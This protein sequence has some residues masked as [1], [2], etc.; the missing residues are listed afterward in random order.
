MFYI[1]HA[2]YKP[3]TA[4]ANRAFSYYRGLSE[5]GIKAHVIY[6]MPDTKRSKVT[7][8]FPGITFEY[9]WDRHYIDNPLLRYLSYVTYLVSFIKRLNKGDVVYIY[10]KSDI[11]RLSV[12]RKGIKVFYEITEH[13]EVYPPYGRASEKKLNDYI[14]HCKKLDGL[15]VISKGLKEYFISKGVDEAKI[16][17]A[18]MMVDD[19]RFKNIKKNDSTEQ[20]ITFC[21]SIKNSINGVDELIKAFALV[22][23]KYPMAK[24][25][26]LGRKDEYPQDYATDV[27][28]VEDLGLSE[29]VVF[30]GAIPY[31]EAP[32]WLVNSTILVLDRPD[33]LQAK[34]GFPTKLG[35]YLLSGN[36]VVVTSVGDIPYYLKDKVNA[37]L[38][39]PNL[40]EAFAEKLLW[41]LDNPEEAIVVGERGKRLALKEFNYKDVV[42][43]LS[44]RLG[45]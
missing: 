2:Q 12:G 21:G 37:L 16:S 22:A 7:E 29:R 25:H 40:P 17:I 20:R 39:A 5:L 10:A 45:L 33:S 28:L 24:L 9:M 3:S 4:P 11:M 23:S 36:P 44:E 18:N 15:F 13:P 19:T 27:K 6:F 38:S 35:E 14:A 41:V 1:I 34:Y 42:R 8:E 26:I 30:E 31:D 32:Q 43:H